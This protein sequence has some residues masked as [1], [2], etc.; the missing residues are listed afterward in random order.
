MKT[1]ECKKCGFCCKGESTVSLSI[2]EIKNISKFLGLSEEKFLKLYTVKK[3]KYR[4]EM[5]TVNGYCVFFDKETKLCK[6]HPVKPAKCKEWPFVSA[7]F[8]YPENFYIIRQ[9][10][11]GLK[12]FS[13]E[14]LKLLCK[15]LNK[16]KNVLK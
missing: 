2:E 10:C 5:K 7:I 16:E 8:K 4:I 14:D 15:N 11:Q 1:F 13:W 12:N 3:G 6:I 9:F